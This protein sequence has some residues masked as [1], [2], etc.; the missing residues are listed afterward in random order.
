MTVF[1]I[2]NYFPY[3]LCSSFYFIYLFLSSSDFLIFILL[4]VV[5]IIDEADRMVDDGHFQEMIDILKALPKKGNAEEECAAVKKN[6]KQNKYR[7]FMSFRALYSLTNSRILFIDSL[8]R[9]HID[10][11]QKSRQ[12]FV[13]SATMSVVRQFLKKT[14][15]VRNTES[16]FVGLDC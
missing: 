13:C 7:F 2:A 6:K 10:A 1:D 15:K 11:L 8:Q 12:T 5:Q 16:P 14:K 9:N 3:W 4:Y